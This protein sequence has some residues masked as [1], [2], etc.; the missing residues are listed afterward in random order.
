[1]ER[2]DLLRCLA[3][4]MLHLVLMPTEACNFRCTY[5]YEDFRYARMEPAVRRGVKAFLSRRAADLNWLE[6]SWFGGE[7]LLAMDVIEDIS[8]HV[9]ELQRQFPLLHYT[10]EITTNAYSLSTS[11]FARLLDLGVSRYQ[12]SFDGPQEWHDRKR[13]LA[14]GGGTFDRIWK[15]VLGMRAVPRE[16]HVLVRLHVDQ[17][18]HE[19]LPAFIRQYAEAFG[20]DDRFELFIRRLVCLGGP[21]DATLPVYDEET[22]DAVVHSLSRYAK[23]LGVRHVLEQHPPLCYATRGNSYLVRANGWLNKCTVALEHP[24]NQV[25]RLREDGLLDLDSPKMHQWMRGLWSGSSDELECPMR[26]YA[27]PEPS[28]P[29]VVVG[30]LRV[31]GS[32]AKWKAPSTP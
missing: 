13:V 4:N 26:G 21:N 14:G 9:L 10:G 7:P 29:N 20:Q 15:N 28:R 18:N 32:A 3:N 8:S 25:G 1:M 2:I 30:N 23:E 17:E 24:N 11:R 22:G 12:I 19:A 5:C 6:M 27:D 31:V 16:F